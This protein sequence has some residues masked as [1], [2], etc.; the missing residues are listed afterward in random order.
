MHHVA[1]TTCNFSG[2]LIGTNSKGQKSFN[3][4]AV[5]K[6]QQ[7]I[8]TTCCVIARKSTV[9][10]YVAAKAWDFARIKPCLDGTYLHHFC[11]MSTCCRTQWTQTIHDEDCHL[12]HVI[13][14]LITKVTRSVQVVLILWVNTMVQWIKKKT[15]L[16][17]L[18]PEQ[19]NR[20]ISIASSS[21]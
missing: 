4:Q 12:L 16:I 8:M 7:G 15:M 10:I 21:S 14:T 11:A 18:V 3:W 17:W 1:V 20:G 6:S 19:H 2:H 5:L 13:V 9:L